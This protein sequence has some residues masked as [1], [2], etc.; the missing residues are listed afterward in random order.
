MMNV[1]FLNLKKQYSAIWNEVQSEFKTIFET[2]SFING[3]HVKKFE[4]EIKEYLEV[5]ANGQYKLLTA[6]SLS[7]LCRI[8]QEYLCDNNNLYNKQLISSIH[9]NP[10]K[11]QFEEITFIIEN[12]TSYLNNKTKECNEILAKNGI[13]SDEKYS[14]RVDISSIIR[15]WTCEFCFGRTIY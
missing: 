12:F 2:T 5:K 8:I 10:E 13:I 7:K 15:L 1:P 3:T 14:N 11:E 4:E 9:N 6:A